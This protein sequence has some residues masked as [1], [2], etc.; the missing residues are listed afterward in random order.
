M[1]EEE[2]K[3]AL[4]KISCSRSVFFSSHNLSGNP[5][6]QKVTKPAAKAWILL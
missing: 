5:W 6:R 3:Q 4:R 1:A 2:E